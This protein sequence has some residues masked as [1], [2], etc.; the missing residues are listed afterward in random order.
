M[1]LSLCSLDTETNILKYAGAYNECLVIR[2]REIIELN[3]DKQPI[4]YFSHSKSFTQSEIQLENGDCVY[5]FTDG[6][7]D[8]FGGDKGKKLKSKPF[9]EFLVEISHHK[10][11][12]QLLLIQEKFDSWKGN[13]DQVDDVCVFGIKIV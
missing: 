8:Q 7:V 11:D 5:Q 1:D 4:G 9:K 2:N 6:Y 3:P 13:L 10:M 12:K